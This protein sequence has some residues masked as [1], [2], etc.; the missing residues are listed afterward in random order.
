MTNNRTRLRSVTCMWVGVLA[1][2]SLTAC[3]GFDEK[4]KGEIKADVKFA[5]PASAGGATAL[6][7][8]TYVTSYL[9]EVTGADMS[10]VSGSISATETSG[11]VEN[12]PA[13]TGRV[14][15]IKAQTANGDTVYEGTKPDCNGSH[16]LRI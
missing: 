8:N 15:T 2:L 16:D 9:V 3:G 12:I 7:A 6:T 10:V 13:G 11:L 1:V 14:V 4:P 5:G